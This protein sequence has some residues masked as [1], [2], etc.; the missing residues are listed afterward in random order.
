[1]TLH[2]PLGYDNVI[3]YDDAWPQ[4][5]LYSYLSGFPTRTDFGLPALAEETFNPVAPPAGP[6]SATLSSVDSEIPMGSV[7]GPLTYTTTS[8]PPAIAVL[9]PSSTLDQSSKIASSK[10]TM[11]TS[12]ITT[13]A[14]VAPAPKELDTTKPAGNAQPA[15]DTTEVAD[16][17]NPIRDGGRDTHGYHE[18]EGEDRERLHSND[19]G[20]ERFADAVA[21]KQGRWIERQIGRLAAVLGMGAGRSHV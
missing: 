12:V 20:R 21:A 14:P 8:S 16:T 13:A 15:K 18:H 3:A 19:A 6:A 9:S 5:Y 4:L 11:T 17:R 2:N 1:L 7:A 10:S